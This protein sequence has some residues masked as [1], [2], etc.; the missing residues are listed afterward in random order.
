MTSSHHLRSLFESSSPTDQGIDHSTAVVRLLRE[1]AGR[2]S[3]Q[4]AWKRHVLWLVSSLGRTLDLSSVFLYKNYPDTDGRLTGV[5]VNAWNDPLD[6]VDHTDFDAPV[7]DYSSGVWSRL[8]GRLQRNVP[9]LWQHATQPDE[10]TEAFSRSKICCLLVVPVFAGEDWWGVLGAYAAAE[11]SKGCNAGTIG[12]DVLE[13]V[14]TAAVQLG[15]AIRGASVEQALRWSERLHRIQR[16]IALSSAR[17]QSDKQSLSELLA[18]V[19]ELGGFDSGAVEI[20]DGE[21]SIRMASQGDPPWG[22]S[23]EWLAGGD[24]LA[25]LQEPVYLDDTDLSTIGGGGDSLH[26]G[27]ILPILYHSDVSG[28]L[29][30]FSRARTSVPQSVRTS[31]EAV[32]TEIGVL[33]TQVKTNEQIRTINDRYR[34]A[35]NDGRIGVW[36]LELKSGRFYMDP[37]TPEMFALPADQRDIRLPQVLA[38]LPPRHRSEVKALLRSRDAGDENTSLEARFTL[39]TGERRWF[40]IRATRHDHDGVPAT[41]TGTVIDITR[42][43]AF[44]EE[45]TEA[46]RLADESSRAKGEFLARM[47]HELRTPLNAILG[48]TQMLQRTADRGSQR[49]LESIHQSTRHLME[50]VDNI[51]GQ[52]ML[53]SERLVLKPSTVR[54]D[55]FITT[56]SDEAAILFLDSPVTFTVRISGE[57]PPRLRTDATRL[58]Q[59]LL[60]L[61]GNAAKF[62]ERGTVQLRVRWSGTRLRFAVCDTGVGI[63]PERHGDVFLPFRNHHQKGS[64][65]GLGLSIS[66]DLVTLM[67]SS[68]YLYSR[69]GTGSVFWFSLAT[70]DRSPDAG[71]DSW[72]S[73]PDSGASADSRV[74]MPAA[75]ELHR[76]RSLIQIG[77]IAGVRQIARDQIA[78]RS[79]AELFYE[80]VMEYA[81]AFRLRELRE[82][83]G[84]STH[85]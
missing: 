57:L 1:S 61:I 44:Q 66:R 45:L 56:I 30:L 59:V 19:C 6:P 74:Q 33:T 58:R 20:V 42:Q 8:T 5:R 29:L 11:C 54:V 37:P 79:P 72:E 82:L 38:A 15:N 49:A 27:A 2:F 47:S 46:Q 78:A 67:D 70:C 43:R 31:L 73:H 14:S 84:S 35:V 85:E 55:E 24:S 63:P 18:F 7:V 4:S 80:Q 64:G 34:R 22:I 71:T 16:D 62:T 60:N 39:P 3:Q 10:L 28:I 26:S 36:E 25:S 17:G 13:V 75:E 53:E 83:V 69:V 21:R 32:V 41:V 50:M 9:V 81:A 65:T 52:N 48:H 77:D 23:P 76:L 51:L 12:G 40:A 68:L